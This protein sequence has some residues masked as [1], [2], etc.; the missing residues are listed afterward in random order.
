MGETKFNEYIDKMA[1]KIV[2]CNKVEDAMTLAEE[3]VNDT[4]SGARRAIRFKA[5]DSYLF[6]ESPG[7]V[8]A[9]MKSIP[10][11]IE[12]LDSQS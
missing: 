12:G 4:K 1:V 9:V 7:L 2:R 5:A 3:I 6:E 10:F 8:I 11:H